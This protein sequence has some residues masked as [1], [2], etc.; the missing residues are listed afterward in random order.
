VA[1]TAKAIQHRAKTAKRHEAAGVRVQSAQ[2]AALVPAVEGQR[3]AAEQ[4]VATLGAAKTDKPVPRQQFR[5]KLLEAID[6]VVSPKPK[7]KEEADR[8][9]SK[10]AGQAS[11]SLRGT[12]TEQSD[13]AAGSMKS[14]A[15][16]DVAA[17][18]VGRQTTLESEQVG[19]PPAAV[20]AASAVPAPLPAERFDYSEDRGSTEQLMADS[21]VT[22][23]QLQKGNEPTFNAQLEAR[24]EADQHETSA[25]ARYRER[26]TGVQAATH[27]AMQNAV[28]R[29]LGDMHG[30]RGDQ[31]GSVL[32]RQVGTSN[33]DRAERQRITD[34]INS[35]KIAT[36]EAVKVILQDLESE[37]SSRFDKGLA[38]AEAVYGATF[39][40]AK[41]GVVNWLTNWG[42]DWEKL[43]ESSL[44]KARSA[45]MREVGVAIDEVAELVERKLQ[46]AKDRVAEGSKQVSDF[47]AGLDVSVKSFGEQACK[48]VAADFVAMTADIDDRGNALVEKL[49]QQYKASHDRMSA[50]EERLREENKSLWQRVY[51]ATVG[52]VK[53]IL[54]FKDMLLG[55]LG[56]AV[57]VIWDILG[58]PIGFLGNLV[59]GVAGGLRAFMNN[60]GTH[61]QKGLMDWMFGALGG[62]GL[63]LP[64]KFDLQGIVSIV[65]QVLGLTYANFR[66]RAV[67]IVGEPIV[68][69]LERAAE[70]FKIVMT[71]GIG[72]LWQ[73]IKDQLTNLKSMVMDAIFDFIRER[74]IIAGITW[75]IGL[76]NPASAFFKACKAI[77]DIVMFFINRGSQIMALV[78]AVID[79]VAAIA[80]GQ[81]GSAI[82]WIEAA[83]AKAIP[84][85]IGFLAGLLGLGDISATI[86]KTIDKAQAPVNAAIDWVINKAVKLVKAAGGLLKTG[87]DKDDPEKQREVS[88]GLKDLHSEGKRLAAE[89]RFAK[90]DAERVA[91]KVKA[92]HGVFKSITVTAG[93]ET[94]DYVYIASPARTE[95]GDIPREI[96]KVSKVNLSATEKAVPRSW[97]V[98][99]YAD[100][101]GQKVYWGAVNVPLGEDPD[102]P[103]PK[104]EHSMFLDN[105]TELGGRPIKLQLT[106]GSFTEYALENSLALYEARY[107]KLNELH[108]DLRLKNLANFQKEYALRRK[109][110]MDKGPAEQE[111]IRAISFGKAR[112]KIG[113]KDFEVQATGH[114]IINIAD[115]GNS[116]V[117]THVFVVARR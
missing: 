101:A 43:I 5:Q 56:R 90:A 77:Y 11:S 40:D 1:K 58:D 23:Q 88:A 2:G 61:L 116:Y 51:D 92:D 20:S 106:D 8:L 75:I 110:E 76:L 87:V 7:T 113:F 63:K 41:G 29:G 28:T 45:Y 78:S 117:P 99:L 9:I 37:A 96:V 93:D 64:D 112:V 31:V 16:V 79:S 91:Q 102:L 71:Q 100:V 85:A 25:Q 103:P 35:I 107:G 73:F 80:K 27:G 42:D 94:W 17:A 34:K 33:K 32:D 98:H 81:L 6:K 44:E 14:A 115:V 15:Q 89:K 65:L 38:K 54:A 74:V 50:M 72:G 39:E 66:K 62:A 52:L 105:K 47:V 59:A 86:R 3:A 97:D 109:Q 10:G 68:Q 49:A 108:G 4:T 104:P 22:Q 55:I 95:T 13:V 83:L 53:K 57:A 24:A 60:I 48:D 12:L 36:R 26:E 18:P 30:I 21:H 84:V 82:A 69:G 114:K 111:A 46:Q 67:A 19:S 70:I